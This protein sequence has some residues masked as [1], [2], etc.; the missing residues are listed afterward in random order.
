[1][2]NE[3]NKSMFSKQGE[4]GLVNAEGKADKFYWKK[5][6]KLILNN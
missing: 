2:Y 1:M 3:K 5:W 6:N 4:I